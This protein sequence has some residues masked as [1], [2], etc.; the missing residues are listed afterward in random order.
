MRLNLVDRML[1]QILI[2]LSNNARP[3]VGMKRFAQIG[4]LPPSWSGRTLPAL[5]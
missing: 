1:G 4:L 2:D 5:R 3:D